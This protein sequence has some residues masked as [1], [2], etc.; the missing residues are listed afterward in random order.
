MKDVIL[1]YAKDFIHNVIVHPL[2]MLLP[3]KL[4]TKM[5]DINANWAYGLNRYDEIKLESAKRQ[6]AE[7]LAWMRLNETL[8]VTPQQ[9]L[10]EVKAQA[11]KEFIEFMY[12]SKDIQLCSESLDK[13][14][15]YAAS[16]LAGKE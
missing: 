1:N 12:K 3:S 4:A 7:R 16:I 15:Q 8:T 10:A 5:H 9:H 6:E 11:V 13:A 14:N 2:M